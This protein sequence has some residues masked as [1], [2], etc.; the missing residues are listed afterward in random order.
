MSAPTEKQKFDN[1]VVQWIND[2]LPIFT[3]VQKEYGVFPMPKNA[4][5][6]WSFGGILMLMLGIMIISGIFLAMNYTPHTGYAFDSVER[7]M[8]DV[9]FG[10][11]M[12]YVHMNGASFFFIAVY[13]H[14]SRGLYTTTATGLL[15]YYHQ[16]CL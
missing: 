13:I 15:S 10:W 5:Y 3:M 12:R 14:I 9:N 8:R 1:Q 4:N 2:R 7:V 16:L 11:L 6:L